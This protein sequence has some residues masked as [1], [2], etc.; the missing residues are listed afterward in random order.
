[1]TVSKQI[2]RDNVVKFRAEII[3]IRISQNISMAIDANQNIKAKAA[4]WTNELKL[5]LLRIEKVE[6]EN[7][8]RFMKTIKK[9]WG[10]IY[11]DRPLGAQCLRGNAARFHND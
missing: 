4:E 2:S 9:A 11:E 3:Q 10:M 1:M 7:G 5:N 8:R 6:R